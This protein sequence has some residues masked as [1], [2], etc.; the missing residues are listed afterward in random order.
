MTHW[1][2]RPMP[3]SLSSE[4]LRAIQTEERK[5][6]SPTVRRLLWEVFRLQVIALRADQ[7]ERAMRSDHASID[8]NSSHI[9]ADI[10]RAALDELPVIVEARD[11]RQYLLNPPGGT[12]VKRSRR[13]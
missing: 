4:E 8:F 1:A 3:P 6:R 13:E 5:Q 12:K 10:L 7:F 9:M 11:T 2:K